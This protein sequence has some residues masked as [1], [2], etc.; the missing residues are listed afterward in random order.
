M[1]SFIWIGKAL[2]C[3]SIIAWRRVNKDWLKIWIGTKLFF[4]SN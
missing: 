1:G 3:F 4:H 2:G